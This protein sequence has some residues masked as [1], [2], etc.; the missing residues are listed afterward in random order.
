MI[1][2]FPDDFRE[3]AGRRVP[4]FLFDYAEGGRTAYHAAQ[5]VLSGAWRDRPQDHPLGRREQALPVV[6][7][8]VGTSPVCIASAA[9]CRPRGPLT[10][11]RIPFTLSTVSLCSLSEV[12]SATDAQRPHHLCFQLYLI[13]DRAFMRDALATAKELAVRKLV[14]TVDT[15]VQGARYR[16]AHS[17]MSRDRGCRSVGYCRL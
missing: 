7:G 6:L 11:V 17:G 1:I 15:P 8:P 10:R 13:R 16:D 9:R 5:R 14:F 2:A 3:A 4:R 12:T